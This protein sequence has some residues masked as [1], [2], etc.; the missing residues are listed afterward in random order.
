[1][2]HINTLSQA[3]GDPTS[4]IPQKYR[5]KVRKFGKTVLS[6]MGPEGKAAAAMLD[7]KWKIGD[8]QGNF[9]P[10]E[11]KALF[12]E[13]VTTAA[14]YYASGAL[15]SSFDAKQLLQNSLSTVA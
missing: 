11:R 5:G 4:L 3:L 1:M 10:G 2:S 7:I 15:K 6:S 8:K 13:T 9:A 12:K 14:N